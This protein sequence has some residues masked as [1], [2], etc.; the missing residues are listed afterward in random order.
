MVKNCYYIS[1]DEALSQEEIRII[2]IT[3]LF[4]DFNHS[5]GEKSD[6]ENIIEAIS[7]FQKYTR[8]NEKINEK[9][10]NLIK[11]TEYPYV[12]SEVDISGK[13]IRDADMLQW[14]E[15]DHIHQSV[16]GLL[17]GEFKNP[18]LK[19]TID[20]QIKYINNINLYTNYAKRK[21]TKYKNSKIEEY[22]Y[23]KK[24]LNEE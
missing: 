13:I 8:E 18:D 16:F 2:L 19:R 10:I 3:C 4:H 23:I 22:E 1:K 11:A 9:V 20:S 6:K 24:I 14:C 21:Y 12:V 15:D 5:M 17:K 7:A